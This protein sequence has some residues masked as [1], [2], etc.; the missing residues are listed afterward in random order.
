MIQEKK[1]ILTEATIN[2]LENEKKKINFTNGRF[3]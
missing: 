2:K 3:K 1:N